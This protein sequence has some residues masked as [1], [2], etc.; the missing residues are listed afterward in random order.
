MPPT[1]D[2]S[3]DNRDLAALGYRPVLNRT[4]GGFSSFAAG[5]SYISILT[6]VFQMFHVGYHAGGP[7]FFW[8]WPAVALG[9]LAVGLCFAELAARFPLSGGVYQWSRRTGGRAVGWMA[10]WIYLC[11]SVLSLAAVALALQATM[12]QI[13]RAFQLVGDPSVQADS[14]RNAVI[15]GCIL[16][17]ATTAINVAGVRLMSRINNLGVAAELVGVL[18]LIGLLF[19]HARRGP[20]IL[21]D[22]MG[23][24]VG[25]GWGY[26]APALAGSLTAS[27]VLYG[28]D[29]AGTLAEE[30]SRPRRRAPRGILQAPAA[31]S[32]VGALLIAS[33]IMAFGDP[34]RPELGQVA[35]GL[36][37]I[38]K[39]VLGTG[40]GRLFLVDVVF[41]VFVCALAVQ[42][43]TVRL[44]FAMARD[45]NLPFSHWL[46]RVPRRTQAPALPAL[47]V[48]IA[49]LGLLVLNINQPHVIETL[50]AVA[51]VWINLA[52]LLV[53][54]PMLVARIRGRWRPE[55]VDPSGGGRLFTMGRLGGPIN[56]IAAAWGRGARRQRLVAARVHLWPRRLEPVRGPALDPRPARRGRAL[57]RILPA[58]AVARH[59][60]RV[61][62]RAGRDDYRRPCRRRRLDQPTRPQQVKRPAIT[63][64]FLVL[65]T[66][67]EGTRSRNFIRQSVVAAVGDR[68][69]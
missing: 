10:G 25:E 53:T 11:G 8:T 61:R 52:Y 46:G 67:D 34:S 3:D 43:G 58:T 27:Y 59:A 60:G 33:A 15:L 14:A 49:G 16:I 28:F 40:L 24:S 18:L 63:P 54:L 32:T 23:R 41:A 50:C 38:V 5:F 51:I 66:F 69:E 37:M 2:P 21:L 4:L 35:G 31:A 22:T 19:A 65:C 48:G 26:L 57:L 62:P 44:I 9:Q 56:A 12:P 29:T 64:R 30:T 55:R 1:A 17:V 45:D 7:A 20:G 42:A 36:P 39:D 68:T 6:G 13:A 47:L